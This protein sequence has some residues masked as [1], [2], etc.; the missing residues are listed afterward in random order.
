MTPSHTPAH[1]HPH[2]RFLRLRQFH[3]E[4][5]AVATHLLGMVSWESYE[6][7]ICLLSEVGVSWIPSI[8]FPFSVIRLRASGLDG[9]GITLAPLPLPAT[10]P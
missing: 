2:G 5:E 4:V 10:P 3:D 1:V 6:F 8:L 9:A 7:L